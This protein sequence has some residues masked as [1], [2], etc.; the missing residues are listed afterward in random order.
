MDW[1]SLVNERGSA[2]VLYARQWLTSHAEAEDAV[3]EGF[4]R[5]WRAIST[6]RAQEEAIVPYLYR[7]VRSAALDCLRR[8]SRRQRREQKDFEDKPDSEPFF[9]PQEANPETAAGLQDALQSLPPEQR[10]VV[11]MKVWGEQTFDAI[12]HALEISPNTAASRYRY[13][14]E[15]LRK[16]LKQ[17]PVT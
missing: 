15:A 8:D 17:E 11:V 16:R 4:V 9:L 10:E 6:G 3:Q 13:G 2:L 1:T 5:T 14:M 12:G 7:A